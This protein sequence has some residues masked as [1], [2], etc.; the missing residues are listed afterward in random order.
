MIVGII[1]ALPGVPGQGIL[2]ILVGLMFIDL[3][4]KR[5][6]E[7][8]LVQTPRILRVINGLRSRYCR[9]ELV[10]DSHETQAI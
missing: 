5:K 4:G 6:I 2:T 3:P 1:L 9:P 7:Q 8:R 10:F